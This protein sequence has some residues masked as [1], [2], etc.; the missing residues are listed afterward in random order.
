MS[1][2]PQ[3][4]EFETQSDRSKATSVQLHSVRDTYMIG[5]NGSQTVNP[6]FPYT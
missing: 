3:A 6:Y 1:L 5:G 4:P 2:M